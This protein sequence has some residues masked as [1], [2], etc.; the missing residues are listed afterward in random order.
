MYNESIIE[1][2]FGREASELVAL[3]GEFCRRLEPGVYS[4]MPEDEY[5]A[6]CQSADSDRVRQEIMP[7]YVREI[8]YRSHIAAITSVCKTWRWMKGMLAGAREANLFV[9]AASFRGL[10][11]CV[12]DAHDALGV[13][14][15]TIAVR[16]IAIGAVLNGHAETMPILGEL[17]QVLIHYSHATKKPEKSAPGSKPIQQYLNGIDFVIGIKECYAELCDITHPGAKAVSFFFTS[18][19]MRAF[20]FRDSNDIDCIRML[21]RKY[22]E[23]LARLISV[24]CTPAFVV[25]RALR[26]LGMDE[27][28]ISNAGEVSLDGVGLWEWIKKEFPTIE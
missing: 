17:E 11:E 12:A 8:L 23:M 25:L 27:L 14:V 15:N 6:L 1:V 4:F 21:S 9:Y 13:V 10:I 28:S 24:V 2:A 7:I 26:T 3:V 19:D 20:Q 18:E 22:K 5:N 16:H